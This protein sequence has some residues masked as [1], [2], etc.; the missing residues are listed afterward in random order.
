MLEQYSESMI[1]DWL[2]KFLLDLKVSPLPMPPAW[3]FKPSADASIVIGGGLL[4]VKWREP[5]SDD[6][7]KATFSYDDKGVSPFVSLVFD[8]DN[9]LQE[10]E[11][12]RGDGAALAHVPAVSDL[13]VP[14]ALRGRAEGKISE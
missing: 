9:V 13:E 8:R 2:N 5:Q 10:L 6:R 14:V 1:K 4:L 3:T 12:W 7:L 11:V